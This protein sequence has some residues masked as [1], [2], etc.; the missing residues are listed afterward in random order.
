[1]VYFPKKE[2]ELN[3]LYSKVAVWKFLFTTSETQLVYYHQKVISA[4]YSAPVRVTSQ[5]TKRFK[6]E[7]LRKLG[8][9]KKIPEMLGFDCEYPVIHSKTKLWRF[10]VKNWEKSAVKHSIGKTTSFNVVNL[11]PTILSKI[12]WGNRLIFLTRS[13]HLDYI[14]F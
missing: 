13:R 1:M 9:F 5:T 8:N 2:F 4:S 3:S 14:L 6:T 11:F 12:L 10:S 7:D